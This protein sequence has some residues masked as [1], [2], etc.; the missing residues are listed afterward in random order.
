MAWS[1]GRKMDR[2][3][4][5]NQVRSLRHARRKISCALKLSVKPKPLAILCRGRMGEHVPWERG[6]QWQSHNLEIQQSW[7]DDRGLS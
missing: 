1:K 7:R 5:L 6:S 3:V 4:L 2:G